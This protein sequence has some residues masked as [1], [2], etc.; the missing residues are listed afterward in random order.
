MTCHTSS[1][2][3]YISQSQ[4][5]VKAPPW[6]FPGTLTHRR[7]QNWALYHPNAVNPL[8]GVG[9]YI[10]VAES[11]KRRI[12]DVSTYPKTKDVKN[13]VSFFED[14]TV[15]KQ[16]SKSKLLFLL[17]L[18]K[19]YPWVQIVNTSHKFSSLFRKWMYLERCLSYIGKMPYLIHWG[20]IHSWWNGSVRCTGLNIQSTGF[21]Q[22]QLCFSFHRVQIFQEAFVNLSCSTRQ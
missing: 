10:E 4:H 17:L 3:L 11:P 5:Q 19:S 14:Q 8:S 6:L 22:N 18:L 16:L 7:A 13:A 2:Y 1:M 20:Y 15:K 9:S 21:V 12:Q